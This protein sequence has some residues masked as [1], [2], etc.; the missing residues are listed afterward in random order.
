MVLVKHQLGS[1]LYNT[2]QSRDFQALNP[3]IF[4]KENLLQN[5]FSADCGRCGVNFWKIY[6]CNRRIYITRRTDSNPRSSYK[7]STH[8]TS[9]RLLCTERQ[10]VLSAVYC[11]AGWKRLGEWTFCKTIGGCCPFYE[12]YIFFA[13][14]SPGNTQYIYWN[15]LSPMIL[16]GCINIFRSSGLKFHPGFWKHM[17]AIILFEESDSFQRLIESPVVSSLMLSVCHIMRRSWLFFKLK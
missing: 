8:P 11:R 9:P 7:K 16:Y 12:W 2:A 10:V 1:E 15:C 5:C 6:Y 13:S 3:N 4:S 14:Y 17:L